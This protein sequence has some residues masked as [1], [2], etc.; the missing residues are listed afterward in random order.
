MHHVSHLGGAFVFLFVL[1]VIV[2]AVARVFGGEAKAT[3]EDAEYRAWWA[4]REAGGRNAVG[5]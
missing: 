5:K 3:R 4:G 1:G 2:W